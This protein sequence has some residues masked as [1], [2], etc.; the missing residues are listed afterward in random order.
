[1]KLLYTTTKLFGLLAISIMF[2][3]CLF[4]PRQQTGPNIPVDMVIFFKDDVTNEE[5]NYFWNHTIGRPTA[6][7]GEFILLSGIQGAWRCT[8]PLRQD[9]LCIDFSIFASRRQRAFVR[10]QASASPIVLKI[11]ADVK[12]GE[13]TSEQLK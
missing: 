2:I 4:V 13:I 12:P 8:T 6:K 11:L 3:G 1:M 5:D 9:S 7:Q 10:E